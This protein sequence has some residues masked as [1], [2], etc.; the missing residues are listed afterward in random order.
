[1]CFIVSNLISFWA[2]FTYHIKIY[3]KNVTSKFRN[4]IWWSCLQ[5]GERGYLEGLASRYAD[6]FS[7]HYGDVLGHLEDLR[8]IEWAEMS[9]VE[10]KPVTPSTPPAD[11]GPVNGIG[12]LPGLTSSQSQPIYVPGKYSVCIEHNILD[13]LLI[14]FKFIQICFTHLTL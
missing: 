13:C 8:R 2:I 12:T 14:G 11:Y 4:S 10:R 9:P 7:T 6:L 5:D 1:M 3:H